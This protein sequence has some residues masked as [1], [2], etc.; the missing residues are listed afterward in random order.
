MDAADR[1]PN[2]TQSNKGLGINPQQIFIEYL[3]AQ[4]CSSPKKLTTRG[5]TDR[6][7]HV[8]NNSLFLQAVHSRTKAQEDTAKTSIDS[9]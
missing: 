8:T 7:R 6:G 1:N 9:A 2:I 4:T 5:G 3:A